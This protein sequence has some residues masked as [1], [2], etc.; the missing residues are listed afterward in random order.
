MLKIT[1]VLVADEIEQCCLD[2]LEKGN[3]SVV[4]KTKLAGQA[5]IDELQQHDA[6]VVRSATKVSCDGGFGNGNTVELI[7]KC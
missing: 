6:V 4:K 7:S 1:S 5:L 3:V 2:A